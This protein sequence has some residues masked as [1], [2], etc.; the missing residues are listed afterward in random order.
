MKVLGI[1]CSPRKGGNTEIMLEEALAAARE[2]GA[3]TE[4]VLV[5]DKNIAPCDG[6]A[7]CRK[8]G[9]CKIKDDMQPIYQQLEAADAVILGTPVYFCNVSAQAKAVMDRT[10]LF[11]GDRRLR[12][13]VAAPIMAVR[14]VGAGQTRSLLYSYFMAQG[15]ILVRGGIGYGMAKG[16]VRQGV[17]GT[18]G[19]SALEEARSVGKDIVEMVGRLSKSTG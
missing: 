19:L 8:T 17:G 12:G 7:S 6:C 3:Q 14:R 4:L 13:K 18:Q 9:V 11:L 1:V 2:A 5:A 15:M 10:Y 16:D